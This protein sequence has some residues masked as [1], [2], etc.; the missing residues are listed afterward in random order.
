[1]ELM[2][3]RPIQPPAK[4]RASPGATLL[5][6]EG[7]ST[8]GSERRRLKSVS[9]EVR[10][11]EILGIAGVSGNG[12][13]ELADGIA[14]VLPP[15]SGRLEIAG[16]AVERPSPRVIQDLRVGRI[17]EDRMGVGLLT[18]S[19]LADSLAMPRLHER[20]FSRHG[21]IDRN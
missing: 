18:Q 11:G 4:G 20:P 7:L 10:S 21:V 1:A 6:I 3:G 17:P 16:R 14:G 8:S 2:C 12:Q 5:R 13:R 15:L 19:P 9:V